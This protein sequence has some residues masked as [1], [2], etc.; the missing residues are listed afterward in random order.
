MYVWMRLK[1]LLPRGISLLDAPWWPAST[2]HHRHP[3]AKPWFRRLYLTFPGWI[4]IAITPIQLFPCWIPPSSIWVRLRCDCRTCRGSM[5]ITAT[6]ETEFVKDFILQLV[7]K[8]PQPV[9]YFQGGLIRSTST[10]T[11]AKFPS[12]AAKVVSSTLKV[13]PILFPAL[14]SQHL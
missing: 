6:L 2:L 12:D 3:I 5:S 4:P 10:H 1:P 13:R 8:F 7:K 14:S 11:R 9:T